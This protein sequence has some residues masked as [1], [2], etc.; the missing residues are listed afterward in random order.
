MKK[1]LIILIFLNLVSSAYP[2]SQESKLSKLQPKMMV[3]TIHFLAQAKKAFPKYKLFLAETY[4]TQKRQDYL[5]GKK[6][7][8]TKHS[9]HTQGLAFDI[10]FVKKGR[11][12]EGN[13]APYKELGQIGK[14]L[15][16]TWGGDWKVRDY[17][18]FEYKEK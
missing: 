16:L 1:L 18:H 6:R 2:E 8:W 3:I 14:D 12:L 9:K 7:T 11:I 15:G 10:Y 4:R 17:G 13:E 5:Y